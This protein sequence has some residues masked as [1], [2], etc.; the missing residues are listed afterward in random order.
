MVVDENHW[1]MK[2]TQ[3]VNVTELAPVLATMPL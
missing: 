2:L 3:G 1:S